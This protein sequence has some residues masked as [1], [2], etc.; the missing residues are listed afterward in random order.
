[1]ESIVFHPKAFV[2]DP[3]SPVV[4][5][6][7]QARCGGRKTTTAL[8]D[9][10][11]HPARYIYVVDRKQ[12]IEERVATLRHEAERSGTK[13][14]IE[15][16]VS[17]MSNSSGSKPISALIAEAITRNERLD[18][19]IIIIT[20]KG[21]TMTSHQTY[22]SRRWNLIVDEVPDMHEIK[23]VDLGPLLIPTLR[24]MYELQE[25]GGISLARPI[26]TREID[27]AGIPAL[28]ELHDVIKSGNAR[29]SIRSWDEAG[30]PWYVERVWDV[31]ILSLF[32]SVSFF[33]D[34]FADSITHNTLRSEGVIWEE[35]FLP[36][37]RIWKQRAV[38]IEYFV[39]SFNA[40]GYQ[41]RKPE[42]KTELA[43]VAAYMSALGI[44]NHLWTVS[45][46]VARVFDRGVIGGECVS[47]KQAG[48]NQWREWHDATMIYSAKPSPD[49]ILIH[50]KRGMREDDL[51]RAREGCDIRQFVMRLSL[52]DPDSTAPV[53]VRLFDRDQAIELKT[54]LDKTYGFECEIAHVDLG[55]TKPARKRSA[56]VPTQTPEERRAA[57]AIVNRNN[58]AKRKAA[59]L[60]D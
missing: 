48:S 26:S 20:H 7:C 27:R 8:T 56:D 33:A 19:A 34:S 43:K 46:E 36:D 2:P 45:A 53:V 41:F 25:D 23:S 28:R 37:H 4:A 9:M 12:P 57:R 55:V 31:A 54:Y 52:R 42:I 3:A 11:G 59:M 13:P 32:D 38:R 35:R 16:I 17:G 51:I 5:T 15:V 58:Y 44:N 24:H 21:L 1:V 60:V 29:A 39:R 49:E 30:E 14:M 18:H 40:S 10:S 22:G 50:G 47:P 6:F